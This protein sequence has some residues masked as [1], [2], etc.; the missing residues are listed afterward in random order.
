[1]GQNQ[2]AGDCQKVFLFFY[3]RQLIL[4]N[5]LDGNNTATNGM[6]LCAIL[7]KKKKHV[8]CLECLLRPAQIQ[9]KLMENRISSPGTHGSFSVR[10]NSWDIHGDCSWN[11]ELIQSTSI[12]YW[13]KLDGIRFM[14]MVINSWDFYIQYVWI[15]HGMIV[16]QKMPCYRSTHGELVMWSQKCDRTGFQSRTEDWTLKLVNLTWI[17]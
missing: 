9:R 2:P 13:T 5:M 14:W 4:Q 17:L 1:M 15:W 6:V 8:F 16:P 11:V 12:N 10:W 3:V 7:T